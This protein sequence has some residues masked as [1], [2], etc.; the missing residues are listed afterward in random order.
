MITTG[1]KKFDELLGGGIPN[2]KAV[3]FQ[4]EPGMEESDVAFPVMKENIGKVNTIYVSSIS[5]PKNVYKKMEEFDMKPDEKNFAIIDGYSPL[6]GAPSEEKYV[7]EEPH[8]IGSY[9]DTIFQALEDLGENT[10]LVFDSLSNIMDLC[11]E[12]IALEGIERINN[13]IN[14]IGAYAMSNFIAWP[15]K[16]AILYRI[17]RIFNAIIDV[18]N[19][20]S[21]SLMEIKKAD[22]EAKTAKFYFKIFKPEGL[23]IYIPKII[24]A[25]PFRSGKTTFIKS[26]SKKFF[27][28]ERL[29]ATTGVEYGVVDYN[30]YR[31]DV[32]GIP[33]REGFAPLLDKFAGSSMG[34]I[35]VVD[36]SS[37]ESIASAKNFIEKFKDIPNVVV[38]NKQDALNAKSVEEIKRMLHPYENVI[39]ASAIRGEGTKEAFEFLAEKIVEELNAH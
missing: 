13:E 16:E 2:G 39:G 27:P 26:I 12:R 10:L 37:E 20:R 15:Y 21:L 22:W 19:E 33:G 24:V 17:K 5:S 23:R 9:E 7:V 36:S 38:A 29:G 25:G 18:R 35:I 8:D 31:A 30:G 3:L 28:V 1:I 6:I 11:N 34:A 32:F 4:I 14:K